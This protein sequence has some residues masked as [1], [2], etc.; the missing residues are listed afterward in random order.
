[1]GA[2]AVAVALHAGRSPYQAP[3]HRSA[4]SIRRRANNETSS[5]LLT[6][7]HHGEADAA[8]SSSAEASTADKT[9]NRGIVKGSNSPPGS[10]T[11]QEE[12]SRYGKQRS[13]N[14]LA[15]RD[16]RHPMDQTTEDFRTM[17]GGRNHL[18]SPSIPHDSG[19]HLHLSSGALSNFLSTKQAVTEPDSYR[20]NTLVRTGRVLPTHRIRRIGSALLAYTYDIV[21]RGD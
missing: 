2:E 3:W 21:P 7:S 8:R 6:S 11:Y 9:Q 17:A 10:E 18:P 1:M 20:T 12:I 14:E 5:G 13:A 15:R 16:A 19:Y 4:G